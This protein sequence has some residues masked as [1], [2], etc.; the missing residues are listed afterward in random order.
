MAAHQPD[1]K[2][3]DVFAAGT[4][5]SFVLAE[6]GQPQDTEIRDGKRV[7]IF[8][9]VQGYSKG[10]KTSRAFF[11]GAADVLTAGLWEVVGTPTES[12]F[13]GKKM[14]FEVTYDQSERVEKVVQ[15]IGEKDEGKGNRGTGDR[16]TESTK[17][18][19]T[20][21]TSKQDTPAVL[22]ESK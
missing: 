1:E 16:A 20:V 14:A 13:D 21:E 19:P 18:E 12:A 3:L 8:S 6:I 22:Q 11:H 9:F 10:N 17:I 7:D 15:L 4:P 2:N 5:R